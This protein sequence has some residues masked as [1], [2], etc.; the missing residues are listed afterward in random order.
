MTF[1]SLLSVSQVQQIGPKVSGGMSSQT[2]LQYESGLT[3]AFGAAFF[4]SWKRNNFGF[5]LEG[6]YQKLGFT[7]DYPAYDRSAPGNQAVWIGART[8]STD[9]HYFQ[10]PAAVKWY[11]IENFNIQLGPYVGLLLSATGEMGLRGDNE[12][13]NLDLGALAGVGADVWRLN[14]SLRYQIGMFMANDYSGYRDPSLF[15]SNH[16]YSILFGVGFSLLNERSR[17]DQRHRMPK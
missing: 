10:L 4:A 6:G 11:P 2:N 3:P 7:E 14:L 8:G 15:P 9:M 1:C 12:F 13:K 17:L 5:Q 16:N